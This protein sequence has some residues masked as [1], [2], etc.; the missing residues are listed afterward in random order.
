MRT[1][2]AIFSLALT[3]WIAKIVFLMTNQETTIDLG[4]FQYLLVMA[5]IV[6]ILQDIK[7]LFK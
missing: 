6:C 1:F 2:F 4:I 5:F 7:E 3:S